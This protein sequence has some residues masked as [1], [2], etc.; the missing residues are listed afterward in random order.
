MAF[1]ELDGQ[2]RRQLIDGKQAFM[3]WRA[4]RQ[5]Y[6]HSFRGTMQWRKAK[7]H[8]YLAMRR[9]DH[10][11]YLGRRSVETEKIRREFMDGRARAKARLDRL[12]IK[13][14]A[15]KAVNR[16]MGLG[17]M[18]TIAARV[19]R[20]LDQHGLIGKQAH[21]V[22]T[23]ALYAYE[24]RSGV[25]FDSDLL[26]T[27]DLDFLWDARQRLALLMRDVSERGVMGLLQEVD[28]SFRRSHVFRAENDEA[29]L[30]EF[31]RPE[32]RHE[33]SLPAVRVTAANGDI[34][35]APIAGLE[36][37]INAPKME[38]VVIG[39]DG[40]PAFMSCIDPRAFA[41]HKLWLAEQQGR[42]GLKRRRDTL[43]AEAVAAV[44]IHYMGLTFSARELSSVPRAL[45]AGITKLKRT[46]PRLVQ[47][48]GERI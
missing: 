41:L 10:V 38:E 19:L 26:A 24:S 25:R 18:P 45:A 48:D 28:P 15:M 31:I 7:G 8:E 2:Q 12:G 11:E 43:Q 27:G 20:K 21:V 14:E 29:Y 46:K 16:A 37:L 4:L 13:L 36:W 22:G 42:E 35:P 30:I 3:A 1:T 47:D 17:R 34:E 32:R 39:E 23:H 44:A 5:S 6:E 9:G 40:F 33:A